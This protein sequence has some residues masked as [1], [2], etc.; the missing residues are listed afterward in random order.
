MSTGDPITP[1]D[2]GRSNDDNVVGY[3]RPPKKHQ[4]QPGQSG[5]PRGRPRGRKAAPNFADVVYDEMTSMITVTEKGR[6]K[7]VRAMKVVAK[8]LM[9]RATTQTSATKLLMEYFDQGEERAVRK[10][11]A[12]SVP[13]SDMLNDLDFDTLRALREVVVSYNNKIK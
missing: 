7:Q 13:I 10:A 11:N 3:G 5:N 2:A 4:F 8:S 9:K 1:A 6:E 12:R